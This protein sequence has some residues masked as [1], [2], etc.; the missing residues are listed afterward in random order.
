MRSIDGAPVP[1][2][3]RFEAAV[4]AGRDRVAQHLGLQRNRRDRAAVAIAALATAEATG[5]TAKVAVPADA[6]E[7]PPPLP[8]AVALPPHPV[9]W[10]AATAAAVTTSQ[11]WWAPALSLSPSST[12]S[13]FILAAQLASKGG[14]VLE[15]TIIFD[16]EMPNSNKAGME[17]QSE[18]RIGAA[19]TTAALEQRPVGGM[20]CARD[21]AIFKAQRKFAQLREQ[22]RGKPSSQGAA[23]RPGAV[24][25]QERTIEVLR[26]LTSL[27]TLS[28]REK[29]M[30]LSM[31]IDSPVGESNLVDITFK[32][33]RSANE[34][35][36][37]SRV[38]VAT[39]A[40]RSQVKSSDYE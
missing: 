5:A 7:P 23:C 28:S 38:I 8:L 26:Q 11:S 20:L 16:F 10:A 4:A 18:S 25:L 24:S 31:I 19:G 40:A 12:T 1:D 6:D 13:L 3:A 27:G 29:T 22:F 15:D 33:S 39:G 32:L 14:I 36:D 2:N 21:Q 9:A 34:F 30:L 17:A 35:A 37:L